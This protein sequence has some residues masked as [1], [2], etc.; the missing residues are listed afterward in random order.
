MFGG[1]VVFG[2]GHSLS[3]FHMGKA[4]FT[5]VHPEELKGKAEST[6][7]TFSAPEEKQCLK[8]RLFGVSSVPLNLSPQF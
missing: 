6:E 3:P 8:A 1:E 4:M 2:K 5:I 7:A